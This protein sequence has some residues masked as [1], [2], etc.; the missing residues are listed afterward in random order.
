MDHGLWDALHRLTLKV[1]RLIT[2]KSRK[3][4]LEEADEPPPTDAEILATWRA[5]YDMCKNEPGRIWTLFCGIVDE[6][7]VYHQEQEGSRERGFMGGVV[8]EE[9]KHAKCI[10][11]FASV[12]ETA[13]DCIVI[14]HMIKS[15]VL[16]GSDWVEEFTVPISVQGTPRQ[17]FNWL[18]RNLGL[19]GYTG[20][21]YAP[22]E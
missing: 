8:K 2:D 21:P 7:D 10:C 17:A 3:R 1:D 9:S 20:T 22:I 15:E 12:H 11:F 14:E 6:I 19:G 4:S 16:N 13:K 18:Q 5:F